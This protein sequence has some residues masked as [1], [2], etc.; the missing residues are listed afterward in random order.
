MAVR[1]TL[2]VDFRDCQFRP[3]SRK[4]QSRANCARHRVRTVSELEFADIMIG[5]AG[6]QNTVLP[7][8]RIN[9]NAI[10]LKR[11]SGMETI[12]EIRTG[13]DAHSEIKGV[14]AQRRRV[15]IVEIHRPGIEIEDIGTVCI[16]KPELGRIQ[17]KHPGTGVRIRRLE[18]RGGAM[19]HQ[20]ESGAL[21]VNAGASRGQ[22]GL[23]PFGSAAVER[24][25]LAGTRHTEDG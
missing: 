8:R 11:R 3:L 21:S 19:S 24:E 16:R 22:I 14:I 12:I 7:R 4:H 20:P 10:R 9:E 15:R 17:R 25:N 23:Y 13:V 2:A 1:R 5:T 6:E 18:Y